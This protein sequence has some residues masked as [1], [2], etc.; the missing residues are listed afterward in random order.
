MFGF[1]AKTMPEE[2]KYFK[3]D[4]YEAKDR[5]VKMNELWNYLVP[6]YETDPAYN[7]QEPKEF[8]WEQFPTFFST[9]ATG[10]FWNKAD[11]MNMNRPK[12]THTQ[13]LIAKVSWI[14][15]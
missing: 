14:P 5:E 9:N 13:G 4:E 8:P 10:P 1:K 3:S 6:T 2:F 7:G 15:T 11:V 12:I